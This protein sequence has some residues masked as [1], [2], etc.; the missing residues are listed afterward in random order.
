MTRNLIVLACVVAASA[1][2]WLGFS[3]LGAAHLQDGLP[4][5]RPEIDAARY[6]SIQA[7]L[8]ALPAEGG[9]V[10][11]P[12]GRFEIRRPLLVNKSDVCLEGAGT[13][14]HIVNLN[15]EGQPALHLVHPS[16]GQDRQSELWRVRLANF[17]ITG[18]PKSGHGILARRV[19][20][21]FLHGVT[22]SEHGGDGV[23]LDNCYEDPRVC[24]CLMTYN[25]AVGLNLVSCHDIV[26]SAN[27]FEENQDAL[28]CTDGFNLTMTGNA[29][30]DHLGNGV[31]IENTYGSV[32]AANMIEE[33]RGTAVILDR[34]CYGIAV[35]ANVIAHNGAGIDL[36]D[37]HGCTVGANALTIMK[38][39]AVRIGPGSDRIAVTG[40]SFSNSFIG[41]GQLRR[42]T[43]DQAAAGMTLAGA[44]D[45]AISGNTFS[46]VRPKAIAWEDVR[47]AAVTG[48]VFADAES[49][50]QTLPESVI[51][52]NLVVEDEG[53]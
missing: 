8:D 28:H 9:V 35:S 42:G 17:R 37:A 1:A 39:D 27:Q 47:R 21:I 26:V 34:D 12:A 3:R 5:A 13:A 19:N 33:C 29:L 48:N 31:V 7:A 36:R 23:R 40:N 6:P 43:E 20:E 4:G 14:T 44:A 2:G 38:T 16:G 24:D 32:V 49:D 53:K 41:D 50:H 10:R 45:V 22:V 30:D 46:G 11:L 52:Q 15:E 18:N 51:G 25:K